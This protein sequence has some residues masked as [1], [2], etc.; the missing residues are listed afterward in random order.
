MLPLCL[1]TEV[2]FEANYSRNLAPHLRPVDLTI[3]QPHEL[4]QP[5]GC[6]GHHKVLLP[7]C[8]TW[9]AD[10][11]YQNGQNM[12]FAQMGFFLFPLRMR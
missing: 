2:A 5:H 10:L 6:V 7:R 3:K 11:A 4:I 1:H 9:E 12:D 8:W